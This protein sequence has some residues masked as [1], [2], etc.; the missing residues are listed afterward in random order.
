MDNLQRWDMGEVC[1]YGD[2]IPD[3]VHN[4]TGHF[5]SY[6]DVEELYGWKTIDSAPKDGTTWI[7]V[8]CEGRDEILIA[9]WHRL[10]KCWCGQS[11][12]NGSF[13]KWKEKDVTHWRHIPTPVGVKPRG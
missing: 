2:C 4:S 3:I 11:G 6:S 12:H 5:V 1:F 7:I 13:V 10:L 8:C 9:Y